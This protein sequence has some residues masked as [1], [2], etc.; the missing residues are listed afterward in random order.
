M[1]DKSMHFG[2]VASCKLPVSVGRIAIAVGLLAAT[3]TA[4]FDGA[5]KRTLCIWRS[6]LLSSTFG[7]KSN[8]LRVNAMASSAAV[9]VFPVPEMHTFVGIYSGRH[10]EIYK[11]KM[12]IKFA[13][14]RVSVDTIIG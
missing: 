11:A 8:L 9:A 13:H 7:Y 6:L 2:H 12:L 14:R 3:L 1:I 5:Q 4:L 10:S